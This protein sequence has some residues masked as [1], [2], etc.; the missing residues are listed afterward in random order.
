M[1]KLRRGTQSLRRAC[2]DYMRSLQGHFNLLIDSLRQRCA[3]ISGSA[4]TEAGRLPG[5]SGL[6][7]ATTWRESGGDCVRRRLCVLFALKTSQVIIDLIGSV[8]SKPS[9]D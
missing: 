2:G 7:R 1:S 8:R 4:D 5:L 9:P 6:I 3:F